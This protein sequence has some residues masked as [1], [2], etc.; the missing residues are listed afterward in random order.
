MKNYVHKLKHL[1][2]YLYI[3][4][5]NKQQELTFTSKTNGENYNRKR[6]CFWMQGYKKEKTKNT[7]N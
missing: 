6:K 2:I 7:E 4:Q 1:F 5:K 3:V